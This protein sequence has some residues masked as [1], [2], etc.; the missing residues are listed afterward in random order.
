MHRLNAVKLLCRCL[1][2]HW[3]ERRRQVHRSLASAPILERINACWAQDNRVFDKYA[4][5][6]EDALECYDIASSQ[7]STLLPGLRTVYYVEN[8]NAEMAEELWRAGFHDVDV[9]D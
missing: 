1:R 2:L 7:A 9:A 4:S 6:A 8:L 5:C 3:T